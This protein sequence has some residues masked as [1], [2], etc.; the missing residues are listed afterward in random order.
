MATPAD[1]MPGTATD[2]ALPQQLSGFIL[3]FGGRTRARTWD[4]ANP[5]MSPSLSLQDC[6]TG[7]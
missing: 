6:N 3:I 1:A 5:A 4:P 2:L 7:D